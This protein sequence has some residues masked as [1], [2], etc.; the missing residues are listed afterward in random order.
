[1]KKRCL[2]LLSL[3]FVLTM[4]TSLLSVAMMVSH[5]ENDNLLN[6]GYVNLT[7]RI[8]NGSGYTVQ[9][10]IDNNQW[11]GWGDRQSDTAVGH[12]GKP[13]MKVSAAAIGANAHDYAFLK[14]PAG[15]YVYSAWIKTENYQSATTSLNVDI[16]DVDVL[17]KTA[18]L[19]DLGTNNPP[20]ST[21][22]NNVF[23]NQNGN[24][25][26]D[27]ND[28]TLYSTEFTLE[29]EAVVRVSFDSV[30]SWGTIWASDFAVKAVTEE[31]DP[32]AEDDSDNRMTAGQVN[33]VKFVHNSTLQEETVQ[34]LI[35][36]DVWYGWGDQLSIDEMV[37][38]NGKPSFTCI[39][40]DSIGANAHAW[41]WLRLPA[42]TYDYS[43][44][45]KTENY[46]S[47]TTS[48]NIDIYDV[49]MLNKA[50]E[51]SKLG[52]PKVSYPMN[53]F[54]AQNTDNVFSTADWTQYT[55]GFTLKEESV[56]MLKA[57][58]QH[59]WGKIWFSDFS[60]KDSDKPAISDGTECE[61]GNLLPVRIVNTVNWR[62]NGSGTTVDDLINGGFWYGWGDNGMVVE[63]EGVDGKAAQKVTSLLLGGNMNRYTYMKLE[64]GNY[65]FSAQIKTDEFMGNVLSLG[66]K[67]YDNDIGAKD[68]ELNA[69][70]EEAGTDYVNKYINATHVDFIYTTEDWT[71]VFV[72]FT[73][74]GD[75]AR[76][77]RLG[78]EVGHFEGT[79]WISDFKLATRDSNAEPV[80]PDTSDPDVSDPDTSD[81]DTSDSEND[82]SKN[83]SPDT[84]VM[85]AIPVA[86]LLAAA[87]SVM[88]SFRK[89]K[90][91]RF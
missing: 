37:G 53:V 33:L 79:A 25:E 58:A 30:Y 72:D 1:M 24:N 49:D 12:N 89:R 56:V 9:D 44:W 74:P 84:G 27:T 50:A 66:V 67:V 36:A 19:N 80:D 45:I 86:L 23:Y 69:I 62:D 2:R 38:H 91:S 75:T 11:Y 87:G 16:Y 13:S 8:D 29:T 68:S 20:K 35:D 31:D 17:D 43:C 10:L 61:E 22:T 57:S 5:A 65:H 82:D 81:P 59:T 47:S 14:L 73:V 52:M 32:P 28:W 70:G 34:E 63:D 88:Y 71:N 40:T 51:S 83:E 4:L 6:V 85:F 41:T 3:V 26:F 64:P 55:N 54:Y 48:L 39:K 77:V 42:G 21:V 7:S 60:V 18:E 76:Y 15:K 78:V 46:Q 90:V